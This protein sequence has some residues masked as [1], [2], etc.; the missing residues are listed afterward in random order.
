MDFGLRLAQF[1]PWVN[2]SLDQIWE[3]YLTSL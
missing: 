3:V 2:H 1:R